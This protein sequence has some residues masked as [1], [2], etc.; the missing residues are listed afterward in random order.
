LIG[1]I[2]EPGDEPEEPEEPEKPEE[3]EEE[4]N[5]EGAAKDQRVDDVHL[6]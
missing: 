4:Q 1:D 5:E 3:P 2:E 6:A